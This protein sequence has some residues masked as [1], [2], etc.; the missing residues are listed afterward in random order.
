[1]PSP[2]ANRAASPAGGLCPLLLSP[3]GC[4]PLVPTAGVTCS[5]PFLPGSLPSGI[6]GSLDPEALQ[7]PASPLPPQPA[8]LDRTCR[9]TDRLFIC[10]HKLGTV[11]ALPL[12]LPRPP[13]NP[14]ASYLLPAQ[15]IYLPSVNPSFRKP[16][17][18]LPSPPV[19]LHFPKSSPL[20]LSP[21][22]RLSPAHP[23]P[24]SIHS[25]P[26]RHRTA[27]LG[28]GPGTAALSAGRGIGA[29]RERSEVARALTNSAHPC[30]PTATTT[31]TK[32]PS[33]HKSRQ[34]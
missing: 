14:P 1:M 33:Q 4:P 11:R 8:S 2:R 22:S 17:E 31:N 24:A 30:T 10:L 5:H 20:S 27:P 6:P 9:P 29:K 19:S 13:A 12:P 16:A 21:V 26:A 25:H 3:A 34:K 32:K 15:R 18:A 28:T 23:A 7:F